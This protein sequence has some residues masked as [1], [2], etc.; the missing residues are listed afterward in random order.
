MEKHG[1]LIRKFEE[2]KFVWGS[3]ILAAAI[4][5][6]A[7]IFLGYYPI[8]SHTI[9]RVDMYHQYGPFHEELRDRLVNGRSFLYSWEGGL[10]KD[11]IS[12]FAYY[13]ASPLSFLMVFSRRR[14][15]RRRW[16]SLFFLKWLFPLLSSLII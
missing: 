13:T 10:G 6:S 1:F 8:G 14:I 16:R 11:F 12:Q 2:N 4:M 3:F 9:L 5:L 7:Y 15:C